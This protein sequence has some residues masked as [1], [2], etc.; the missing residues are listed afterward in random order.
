MHLGSWSDVSQDLRAKM[1]AELKEMEGKY[2]AVMLKYD[3][4]IEA[5]KKANGSAVPAR[6][7]RFAD[8]TPAALQPP[9]EQH[10]E[11][12]PAAGEPREAPAQ[13]PEQSSSEERLRKELA[14]AAERVAALEQ[15]L[16]VQQAAHE[17]ERQH[18]VERV[19]HAA[20]EELKAALQ[21]AEAVQR[22]CCVPFQVL[23]FA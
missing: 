18:A 12:V 13:S 9:A 14:D 6:S 22:Q 3:A 11:A 21:L 20:A 10:N 8:E 5:L 17:Q 2:E 15:A 4:K 23:I 1:L 19:K 16:A 7:V